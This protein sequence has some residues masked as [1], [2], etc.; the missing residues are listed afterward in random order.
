MKISRRKKK[1]FQQAGDGW[2]IAVLADVEDRGMQASKYGEKHKVQLVFLLDEHDHEGNLIRVSDFCTASTHENSKLTAYV[3]TLT[4]TDPEEDF[5]TE[6]LIGR[7][8]RLE[9]KQHVTPQGKTYANVIRQDVLKAG[10]RGP[11]IPLDF[12]RAQDRPKKNYKPKPNG[13][14]NLHGVKITDRDV[15]F[16]GDAS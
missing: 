9:T 16:S 8:L 1:E 13:G 3:R 5:D 6:D 2:H 14:L 7:S 15:E 12:I 10:E 4:G 11:G